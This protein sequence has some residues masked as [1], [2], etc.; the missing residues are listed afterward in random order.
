M[1]DDRLTKSTHQLPVLPSSIIPP[2]SD[3]RISP[4]DKISST[5]NPTSKPE[6][7]NRGVCKTPHVSV[8]KADWVEDRCMRKDGAVEVVDRGDE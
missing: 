3:L 1:R 4:A 8:E 5:L 2:E 7:D 6:R